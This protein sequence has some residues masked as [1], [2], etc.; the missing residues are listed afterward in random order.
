MTA[1]HIAIN[2]SNLFVIMYLSSKCLGISLSL[3]RLPKKKAKKK[4]TKLID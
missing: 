2:S 3:V 1:H 4:N